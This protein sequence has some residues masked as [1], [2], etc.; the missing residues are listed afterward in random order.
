MKV[1]ILGCGA[2]A[3][4]ITNFYAE[5]KL[6][7]DLEFF[8]DRDMERAE[9]LASQ[10]DG[11]VVLNIEDL[12]E[13]VD[14][15]IETASSQA[16]R[17]IVP[18]ILEAGKDVIIM[19]VGALIDTSL[20]DK[21]KTIAKEN[22]AC[23]HVPS[24]AIV[25]LDGV[26]AGSI[27]KIHKVSLTTRK[28]PKSLGISADSE[29]VL[30]EGKA[31]DAV[32]KFPMNINVAATLSIACGKEVKVKIIADPGVDRN[33]HE[34]H[35]IGDFGELKTTTHNMRCS[36]NPKTSVLAAYSVIK[37]LKSLNENLKIGT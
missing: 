18:Q 31:R 12:L 26:K 22:N 4:I 9:N 17:E 16:V 2:I 20:R 3:N 21:L 32:E 6:G 37:L 27:G 23:I 25:G 7:V 35:M 10:V 14:I 33:S 15:I 30:Y 34:V 1:G 36:I 8:Y 11:T 28:P 29:I 5:G 13:N 24:G 19:S